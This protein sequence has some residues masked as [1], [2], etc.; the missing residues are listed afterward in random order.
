MR[1]PGAVSQGGTFKAVAE[2]VMHPGQ[3]SKR[4]A[5]RWQLLNEYKRQCRFGLSFRSSFRH[6]PCPF[7]ASSCVTV[8]RWHP[9]SFG[10][11][12]RRQGTFAAS[13]S[14]RNNRRMTLDLDQGL[15]WVRKQIV[16]ALKIQRQID[17][18]DHP[19]LA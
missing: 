16:L 17:Q 12:R 2:F 6:V 9:C 15:A 14:E 3:T 10:P 5:C 8:A 7:V 1:F 11:V 18:G 13:C 19:I 4:R